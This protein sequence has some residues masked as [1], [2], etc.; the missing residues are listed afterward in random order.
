MDTESFEYYAFISYSHADKDIATKLQN[1]LE[2]YHL[3]SKLLQAHP[4]LPKK[5]S[6]IFRDESDLTGKG[7][8]TETLRKNLDV[9]NYLILICSLSSAKS[10]YVNDEVDY[11]INTLHREDRII[12]LIVDGLP[13][14]KDES[15]ECFPPAILGID[16][17]TFGRREAFLRVIATLLRLNFTYIKTR[18]DEERKRKAKIFASVAAVLALLIGGLAWYSIDTF[19]LMQNNDAGSQFNFG[20]VYYKKGDSAKAV[21]WYEK[22][23]A[24]GLPVAQGELGS[25]HHMGLGVKQDYAKAKEWYEKAAANGWA[26]A[27]YSL[28]LMYYKGLGVE[29]DYAK[30][31]EL[32]EKSAAQAYAPA[33]CSL[34]L[35]YEGGSGVKQDYIKARELYEKAVAQDYV[36][37]QFNLGYMYHMGLGTEQDYAKARE[38]YEKAAN[39]GHAVAQGNLGYMYD[40]GLGVAQDYA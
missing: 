4:D 30:A 36:P 19:I 40:K 33:Q 34:G 28:G 15:I 23:A 29:Q 11:F 26:K 9:S 8:L 17:K 22:A 7:T 37:A 39:K 14:A 1:S 18:E 10:V 20:L 21:E 2:R 24:Q 38:L 5:L 12:P 3:P 6:P 35:M 25:M 32:Y 27:Q 13:H 31:K 16:L